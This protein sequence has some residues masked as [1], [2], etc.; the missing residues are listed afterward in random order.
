MVKKLKT[1]ETLDIS[2][3]KL[4][5][6][7]SESAK[8][9][10]EILQKQES[11][12]L[13]SLVTNPSAVA[14][15]TTK[16]DAGEGINAVKKKV[17]DLFILYLTN[18]FVARAVNVRA[19]TLISGG[20]TVE[21]ED[22][23]GVK[24]CE[25]LIENSGG[26][27]CFWQLS[28]NTDIA[29]DGFQEK[30]N[31]QAKTKIVRLKQVHPL[32]LEYKTDEESG[33]II[34]DSKTKEPIGY[35]Q[36]Y[37]DKTGVEQEKDVDKKRITHFKYNSLGDEF[38]GMSTIQPG[39]DTIVRLMNMEYSA[40][41]A[42]VKTA[43]PLLVGQT[44]TKS[45]HQIAQWASILGK[46]NGKDQIFLPEGMTLTMLSPGPQNFN[47]YAE[48]FLNA[49]VACYDKETE[50]LTNDGWKLFKNLDKKDLVAQVDQKTFKI[51]Y[52]KPTKYIQ[53]KRNGK[54]YHFKNKFL[55]VMV[56]PDHQMLFSDDNILQQK[57]QVKFEKKE[58]QHID[59]RKIH[60]PQA[61][62]YDGK[63]IDF[64]ELSS[65]KIGTGTKDKQTK[66]DNTTRKFK[67]EGDVFCE[68]M[69]FYLGDGWC[70]TS[71]NQIHLGASEVYPENI[72]QI[73]YILNKM[74]VTWYCRT[75][76]ANACIQG[77][78]VN[79]HG[80]M[81]DYHFSNVA[82]NEYL[83]QFGKAYDKYVPDVIKK[84]TTSQ[85]DL[86]LKNYLLTDGSG[87]SIDGVHSFGSMSEKLIDDVQ[88]I[89]VKKKRATTKYHN[90]NGCFELYVRANKF[91]DEEYRYFAG[92]N[93]TDIK[94]ID[95]NDNVY[96]V[97]VPSGV[98]VTRRGGR[99]AVCGNC[100][101]VPK[102]VLLGGS[103]SGNRAQ[104]VVLSK[105]FYNLI[106]A[107]Q[108]YMEKYFNEIF[109]EYAD[110]AGFKAPKLVF[111]DIAED[112]NL[113][114]ESAIKLIAAGIIDV[115][116]ARAM[117][118]LETNIKIPKVTQS[119][120]DAVKKSNLETWHPAEAGSPTGSQAGEKKTM[121]NSKDSIVKSTTK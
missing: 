65:K 12:S 78:M 40:A 67:I 32:T 108:R 28:V 83:R 77:K 42:A 60:L 91:N 46:I 102:S 20:Y 70:S 94:Q 80:N 34:V 13:R 113:L 118:G 52:V 50:I 57:R 29:G 119:D 120:S 86:F 18:Q 24:A 82:F 92:I 21:G 51:E 88:E 95:Y 62:S 66:Y 16:H 111:E 19:D 9:M 35:V 61:A 107:N 116:E 30:I 71:N 69:G 117:I 31:N 112:A 48:Y 98:I 90:D 114:A 54:M 53:Y 63:N 81:L 15:E 38:T 27:N 59:N 41:E 45:P 26:V 93:Q 64:V 99:V 14:L 43:N 106:Q 6:E 56:T 10:K 47:E 1:V 87:K 33:K 74:G 39:Y 5:K 109:E 17:K 96:C 36:Y 11:E 68:F 105:H 115:N 58:A 84:S 25:D 22:K 23:A 100:F 37:M 4:D 79:I 103:D 104:D 101:G 85:R 2:K 75:K 73:E 76:K 3:K 89:C 110:M 121:K 7:I 44:N 55:D 8:V 49:V 97:T 72:K